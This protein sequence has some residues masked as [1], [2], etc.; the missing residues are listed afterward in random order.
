MDILFI[1]P[2]C[3]GSH[4]AFCE[5]YAAYSQHDVELMTLPG[6]RWKQRMRGGSVRLAELLDGTSADLIV[7]SDYLNLP[8][9]KC[10][11]EPPVDGLPVV[12]YFHENQL[13]YPL[14]EG[15]KR[16]DEFAHINVTS[17]L[18][19]D[20]VLFN[21]RYH[22]ESYVRACADFYSNGDT[23]P[24]CVADRIKAKS[25]VLPVGVEL[26]SIDDCRGGAS[27]RSGPLTILWNHR[28]E[29]DKCPD[30]FFRVM[31]RLDAQGLEFELAVA[32]QSFTQK[33]PA[34]KRAEK[35]LSHRLR[36]FGT[37]SPRADYLRLLLES[38]VVVSTAKHEFFGIAVVEASYAGCTPI[39]PD[40]LSYP[41]LV[42]PQHHGECLYG[43][44]KELCRTLRR[45]VKNPAKARSIDLS[46]A[47]KRY[48]WGRIA[49]RLDS[50]LSDV[51][52]R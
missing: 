26:D 2:Y 6:K 47:M 8:V 50:T 1:E 9:F 33:P 51:C 30:T 13:T 40:R 10:T 19:A 46:D 35:N 49:P 24:H 4:R 42:P 31:E 12:L 23:A 29:Y 14:R 48:N 17:C 16:E 18:A 32:G 44:E 5:G 25:R 38:D 36:V 11:S 43:D 45:W 28:W 3:V 37:V 22:L 27:H 7:A 20:R 21:S 15:Q 41:E 34:F 52:A 39:L